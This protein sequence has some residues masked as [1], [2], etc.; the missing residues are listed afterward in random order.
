[1]GIRF[2]LYEV[3]ETPQAGM[4][5][6]ATKLIPAGTRLICEEALIQLHEDK[7]LPDLWK[8]AEALSP[9]KRAELLSLAAYN[10]RHEETDWIPAMRATYTGPS[11][12][13]DNLLDRV[14]HVWR[15]Y[16]TNRFTVRDAAGN[17]NHMGLFPNAARMNHSCDPNVFHR[18]NHNIMRLTIHALKDIQPGEEIYT[19]Y[20]DIC[21]PTPERRRILRHWGFKCRCLACT[22]PK[23][24]SDL[25]RR[26][27]EELTAKMKRNEAKRADREWQQWDYANALSLMEEIIGLMEEEKLN[28][29]DTL[30]EVLENAAE[31]AMALGWWKLARDWAARAV[32]IEERCLGTD[33]SEYLNAVNLLESA[34]L[35]R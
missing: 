17:R 33:S 8:A 2:D 15:I 28:E 27:L 19:S 1:M 32:E 21:H 4:G 35:E 5:M 14:L 24:G 12:E 25:R 9:E 6:F 29:S 18:H 31:Y 3:R 20:I 30:G 11:E 22:R 23:T 10:R 26:K 34:K 16:E 7:D 13:F